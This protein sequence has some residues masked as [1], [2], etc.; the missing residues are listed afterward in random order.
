MPGLPIRQ[1]GKIICYAVVDGEDFYLLNKYRWRPDGRGY[2]ITDIDGKVVK[3]HRLIAGVTDPRIH[4]DHKNRNKLDNSKSNLRPLTNAQNAQ[5]KSGR[6][7]SQYRGV[8]RQGY[9]WRARVTQNGKE[10][11][12]GSY[13]SEEVAAEVAAEWR[14]INM[15]YSTED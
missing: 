5:N 11:H 12:L 8:S 10:I 6:G 15:E 2:F 1:G 14:R 4:V 13:D 9:K 7:L 3:L